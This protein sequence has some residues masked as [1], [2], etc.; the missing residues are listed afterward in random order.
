[1]HLLMQATHKQ[2]LFRNAHV[3]Y[4]KLEGLT[5]QQHE[6]ILHRVEEPMEVDPDELLVQHRSLFEEDFHELGGGST[7][8]RQTWTASVESAL[9]AAAHVRPG[10][11]TPGNPGVFN[12]AVFRA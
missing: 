3:Y 1:M 10:R 9:A 6:E 11:T 12:S 8:I 2:W 7:R 5:P 4:C